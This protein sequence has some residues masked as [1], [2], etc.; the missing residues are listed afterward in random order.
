MAYHASCGL[1]H[2]S[3]VP[4]SSTFRLFYS[5]T[6]RNIHKNLLLFLNYFMMSLETQDILYLSLAWESDGVSVHPGLLRA[7]LPVR[8]RYASWTQNLAH[9]PPHACGASDP[10]GVAAGDHHPCGAGPPCPAAG[11]P[12]GRHDDHR[13]CRR[14]GPEPSSYLQVDT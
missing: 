5:I 10:P 3:D 2:C 7:L 1:A 9:D 11:T 8:S 12:G 4:C 14:R 6:S 13:C